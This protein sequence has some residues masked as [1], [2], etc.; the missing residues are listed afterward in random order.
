M[1]YI[2][3]LIHTEVMKSEDIGGDRGFQNFIFFLGE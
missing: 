2:L 3:W 1:K